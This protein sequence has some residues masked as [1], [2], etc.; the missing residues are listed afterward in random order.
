MDREV[1][2]TSHV[3]NQSICDRVG[4]DRKGFEYNA[5]IYV[6]GVFVGG[7]LRLTAVLIL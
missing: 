5:E 7:D 4:F 1:P 6:V 3:T 2:H